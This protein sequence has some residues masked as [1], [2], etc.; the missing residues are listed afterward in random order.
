MAFEL[1][2]VTAVFAWRLARQAQGGEIL[3]GGRVYRAARADWQFEALPAIDIPSELDGGG[4][5]VDDETDPGV[6]RARVYRLRGAKARAERMRERGGLRGKLVGRDLELKAMRDLYR[7][8]AL[9]RAKR[10]LTIVG[11]AGVGKRA[12]GAASRRVFGWPRARARRRAQPRARARR[13][14]Q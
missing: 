8:V 14:A 11:E 12:G 7:D 10:Q 3:V 13:R 5:P 1:E 2:D 6:R 4:I 9:G